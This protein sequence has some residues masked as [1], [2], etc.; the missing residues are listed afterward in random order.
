MRKCKNNINFEISSRLY[1]YKQ[2]IRLIYNQKNYWKFR[3]IMSFRKYKKLWSMCKWITIL[4]K[5][6]YVWN[7]R[8]PPKIVSS[9]HATLDSY[10]ITSTCTYKW[11]K[12]KSEINKLCLNSIYF[13][14]KK[15]SNL[16]KAIFPEGG[17]NLRS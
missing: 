17:D 2:E 10:N 7:V 4:K 15:R 8:I 5:N 13:C 1:I 12:N 14:N 3:Y 6:F 16:L 9:I 11:K